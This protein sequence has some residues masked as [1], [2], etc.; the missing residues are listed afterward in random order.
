MC[1][2]K[3]RGPRRG[4]ASTP[5]HRYP[6]ALVKHPYTYMGDAGE[7]RGGDHKPPAHLNTY[8]WKP[9]PRNL[10]EDRGAGLQGHDRYDFIFLLFCMFYIFYK[11]H[12]FIII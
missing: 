3:Y 2:G 11:Q 4:G 5:H 9:S 6:S 12:T 10:R 1:L 8:T 7:V